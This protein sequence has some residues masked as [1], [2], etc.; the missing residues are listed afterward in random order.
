VSEAV[1]FYVATLVVFMAVDVIACWGLNL[2]FGVAGVLNFA[3]VVLQAAGGYTAAVLTLGPS[4]E[5]GGFQSYIAGAHWP[6]PLPVIAAGVTGGMI[7]GLVGL[8]VLRRLRRDYQ[9]MVLLVISLI[10]TS[11]ATNQRGLFNGD[12]GLVLIPKPL[13]TSLALTPV[14]YQWV[15]AGYCVALAAVGFVVMQRIV[16]SPYGRTLRAIRDN[17]PV[18]AAL[19]RNPLRFQLSAMVVGGCFA[20]VSGALLVMYVG[21]YGPGSWTYPTTFLYL[22]AILVGGTGNNLGTLFG[23]AVVASLINEGT[24]FLPEIGFP[25]LTGAIQWIAVGVLTLAFLWFRPQ[26]IVPERRAR[27]GARTPAAIATAGGS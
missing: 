11:V 23:A 26:G 1:Q 14:A 25:G 3:F 9:A 24:R 10:A 6:F 13:E 4:S 15:Y 2:Q 17:E 18:A 7:A 8:V 19:G 27:K 20:G 16:R 5:T 21:A 22:T 12:A